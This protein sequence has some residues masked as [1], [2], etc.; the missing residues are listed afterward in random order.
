MVRRLDLD[1]WRWR[2]FDRCQRGRKLTDRAVWMLVVIPMVVEGHNEWPSQ[3][4]QGHQE[5]KAA[6]RSPSHRTEPLSSHERQ[7]TIRAD[8]FHCQAR[9][10]DL[11][12]GAALALKQS[13][14][15]ALRRRSPSRK[16]RPSF[17]DQSLC[18]WFKG[19]ASGRSLLTPLPADTR[20]SL[21]HA[22]A[23]LARFGGFGGLGLAALC[24]CRLLGLR[25]NLL[26]PARYLDA[27]RSQ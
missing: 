14:R 7:P 11:S 26:R 18:S 13:R 22:L 20:S 27:C 25:C 5:A 8:T 16:P 17:P 4:H 19:S 9:P 2:Q 15:A 3:E 6:C 24:G 1:L 10:N 23:D 12:R 21:C